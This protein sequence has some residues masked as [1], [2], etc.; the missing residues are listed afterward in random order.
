[1]AVD[2]CAT[3]ALV[4]KGETLPADLVQKVHLAALDGSFAKIVESEELV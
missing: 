1:M 4:W 3:R 2:A